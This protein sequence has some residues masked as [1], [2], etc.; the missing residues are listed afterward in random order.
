[1][2]VCVVV[3]HMFYSIDCVCMFVCFFP[4][5]LNSLCVLLLNE[6]LKYGSVERAR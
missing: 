6:Y 3:V 5:E 2:W 1:M 4:V